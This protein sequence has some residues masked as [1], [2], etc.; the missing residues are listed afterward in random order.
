MKVTKKVRVVVAVTAGLLL[1]ACI[2]SGVPG[3]GQI[4]TKDRTITGFS[5]VAADTAIQVNIHRAP[6]F[7]VTVTL[8][9]NLQGLVRTSVEGDTLLITDT[10]PYSTALATFVDIGMPSLSS[11]ENAGSGDLAATGFVGDAPLAL[12]ATGSGSLSFDGTCGSLDVD[13]EGSGDMNLAG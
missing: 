6:A 3:N 11:I 1:Q 13:V 12:L 4:V 10:R 9:S 7:S 8:D 5:R 2:G